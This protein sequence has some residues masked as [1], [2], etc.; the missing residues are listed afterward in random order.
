MKLIK[1]I[2]LLVFIFTSLTAGAQWVERDLVPY[3]T[4]TKWGFSDAA[5]N[6]KITPKYA[7]V[8]WFSH[9]LAPVKV[10]TKWGYIDRSGKLV[11][12]AK[13]TV[14]KNFRKGFM[15][16]GTEGGDSVL[17]AG[18]SQRTD[19]YEICI[20]SKGKQFKGCPAIPE[21][22]V[23]ENREPVKKVE[24]VKNYNIP[25]GSTFDKIV[26]DYKL[27]DT[28]DTYY[29]AVKGNR[30]GII[31]NKFEI[32]V[33][34]DYDSISINRTAGSP[35]IQAKNNDLIGI[36]STTGT[37]LIAPENTN[38]RLLKAADGKD[39]A[40]V[41]RGTKYY[42][43]EIGN[44]ELVPLGYKDITYDNHGFVITNDQGLQGYYFLDNKTIA[45]KYQ[46]VEWTND[47]E[48][49]RITTNDGR[50][51]YINTVGDE[52]FKE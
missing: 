26:D 7:E 48:Y 42:L 29:V 46:K 36:L 44:S 17:F 30:Y 51:G 13:Y 9:G 23:E 15:P 22:S 27:S 31:N 16:N 1:N 10:G 34:F 8:G 52:Y 21:Q 11:I 41:Q 24:T 12:P 43:R 39:Y 25:G 38:L 20:D 5:R 50:V 32:I 2:A 14:A 18:V 3:R 45:P 40:V 33:P 35:Y 37:Q 47:G 4:G 6:I 28:G 49:L 19:G